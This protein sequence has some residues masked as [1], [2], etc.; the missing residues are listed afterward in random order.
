MQCVSERSVGRPWSVKILVCHIDVGVA[1][2]RGDRYRVTG[3]IGYDVKRGPG[4]CEGSTGSRG[5]WRT[6]TGVDS[7]NDSRWRQLIHYNCQYLSGIAD[8]SGDSNGIGKHRSY[9][10]SKR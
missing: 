9:D 8:D 3:H 1:D 4:S 2:C 5:S 7:S 10:S 6:R